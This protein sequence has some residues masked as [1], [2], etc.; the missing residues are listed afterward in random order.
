MLGDTLVLCSLRMFPRVCFTIMPVSLKAAAVWA[1][2]RSCYSEIQKS[3]AVQFGPGIVITFCSFSSW[4]PPGMQPVR[5]PRLDMSFS[6][7]GV[8]SRDE[9]YSQSAHDNMPSV[10]GQVA[11]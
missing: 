10:V 1:S 5:T 3:F 9:H 11:H 4:A 7:H 6:V 8:V 2:R